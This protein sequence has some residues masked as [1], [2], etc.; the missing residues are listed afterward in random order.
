MWRAEE[1]ELRQQIIA[2]L[3]PS[4]VTHPC[5][6]QAKTRIERYTLPDAVRKDCLSSY[7]GDRF[8][9]SMRYVRA[10]PGDLSLLRE[11]LP[12]R[13]APVQLIAGRHDPI[14]PPV[15]ATFLHERLPASK[16]DIL[17]TGHFTWGDDTD[18][19]AAIVTK[20]W[21]GGYAAAGSEPRAEPNFRASATTPSANMEQEHAKQ[22][23]LRARGISFAVDDAVTARGEPSYLGLPPLPP[24]PDRNEDQPG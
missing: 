12:G 16:L 18:E 19:C 9:G 13:R 21:G 7:E 15:N 8:V 22:A 23:T 5:V 11:L 4:E 6:S 10:Y 3:R 2:G 20:W 24:L 17:E 1:W 14:V